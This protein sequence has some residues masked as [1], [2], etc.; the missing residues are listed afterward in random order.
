MTM[1]VTMRAPRRS[2]DGLSVL[3]AGT[4]YTVTDEF[5]KELVQG[6]HATDTE[7]AIATEAAAN[8]DQLLTDEVRRTRGVVSRAGNMT[9]AALRPSVAPY[10]WASF[11]D[12]RANTN[13]ANP[14]VSGHTASLAIV[15]SSWWAAAIRGDSEFAL[16]Y[17]VS[18][19]PAS[20]WALAT[21]NGGVTTKPISALVAASADLVHVQ[22]GVN[23]IL[24]GDGTTPTAATI[25]GYLQAA[26]LEIL[27]S[28][29][30]VLFESILPCS[31][32]GWVTAGSG[33]AA[34]KQ[35]IADAVNSLMQTFC[36]SL[37]ATMVRYVETAAS[38]KDG[39]GYASA[40]YFAGGIHLNNDGARLCGSLLAAGSLNLLPAKSAVWYP[41]GLQAGPNFI[42]LIAPV[43]TT[44]TSGVAGTFTIN[45]Q[46]TGWD[47]TTGP[48]TEWVITANTLASGEA[49]FWAVLGGDVGAFGG[50]SK[51]A[52][53]ANDVLQGQC[54]LLIDN[55]AG[56]APVGL[57]NFVVRQRCYYQAGGGVYADVGSYAVPSTQQLFTDRV[58]ALMTTP[59][60][61]TTT[62]SAGIEPP[63][64]TKGYGLHIFVSVSQTGVPIRIRASAPSLRKA[65]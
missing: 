61:T 22:Y 53:A 48:Y 10:L 38:L 9:G 45:S 65:A 21:R 52:V 27:K 56:G 36:A 57:R 47:A 46:T 28:G 25:A 16:N 30:A 34:Q 35:A 42:D 51:Y 62:A 3:L 33:T 1:R 2:E 50:S 60:V 5:G 43:I 24:T 37:P 14:D 29:K 15:K 26:V 63:T 59:R 31:A 17:G 32:A 39:T 41:S 20:G 13:S 44:I 4:T 40:A 12:S 18:G 7:N 6:G 11:G 64:H 54:R 8:R 19:D 55:G 49:T 23:D 58:D